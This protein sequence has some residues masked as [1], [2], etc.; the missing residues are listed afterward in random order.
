MEAVE[1]SSHPL[2]HW[3]CTRLFRNDGCIFILGIPERPANP[4]SFF[5]E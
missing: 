4:M 2:G 5:D 1:E 3:I